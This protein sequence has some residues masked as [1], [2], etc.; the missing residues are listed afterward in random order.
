[1]RIKISKSLLCTL[2]LALSM[3]VTA[4]AASI[5]EADTVGIENYNNMGDYQKEHL[6]HSF[7]EV[8][9]EVV[10][11]QKSRGGSLAFTKD[12]IG[13]K[14]EFNPI[15]D[16]MGITGVYTENGRNIE[17]R[18]LPSD[19]AS[20]GSNLTLTHEYG[21][22]IYTEIEKT[23]SHDKRELFN[24]LYAYMS[25]IYAAC[26]NETETFAVVYANWKEMVANRNE[27]NPNEVYQ[28]KEMYDQSFLDRYIPI[29]EEAES[30]IINTYH[31]TPVATGPGAELS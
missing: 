17:I 14:Y 8:P 29:F 13:L 2:F 6:L 18:C 3:P 23:L 7:K 12:I 10:L 26:Y 1:M 25:P 27:G 11:L 21:H 9:D 24:E 22:F 16:R 15:I 31:S 20:I 30:C 19:Y 5:E 28:I 4:Q